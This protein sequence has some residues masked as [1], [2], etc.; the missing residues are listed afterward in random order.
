MKG[1]VAPGTIPG[2][3]FGKGTRFFDIVYNPPVTS[4]MRTAVR[5]GSKAYGG[6]DML[7]HQGAES[8]RIWTGKTADIAV[9]RRA[10][11]EAV[12]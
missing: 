9:M 3:L 4:S 10:A 2:A 7:V 5:K 11:R 6:L 12:A 1:H 8:F